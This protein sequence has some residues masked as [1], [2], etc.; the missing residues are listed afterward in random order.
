MQA[1]A[2]PFYLKHFGSQST[3]YLLVNS[4]PENCSYFGNEL[5]LSEYKGGKDI[6][7]K[8]KIGA[9]SDVIHWEISRADGV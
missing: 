9:D 5:T 6:L 7:C 8:D 4:F 3:F 2:T 1:S